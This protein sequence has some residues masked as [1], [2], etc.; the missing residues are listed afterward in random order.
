ML[1]RTVHHLALVA[2]LAL[3][4]T[5]IG[6]TLDDALAL[7]PEDAAGVMAVP[8]LMRLNADMTEMVERS[9]RSEA[10]IAGRPVDMLAAQLG[11]TAAFDDRG[12]FTAWW[13]GQVDTMV[14]AI[15]VA[16]AERFLSA[17]FTREEDVADD[18]WR[19][20]DQ[21]V[22]VRG[23]DKHVIVST[24]ADAVRNYD[25]AGGIAK[26]IR[27][28]LGDDTYEILAKADLSIWAGPDAIAEM[29]T[30]GLAGAEVAMDSD[31]AEGFDRDMVQQMINRMNTLGD[32]LQQLAL[33]VNMDALG[34]GLKG[35]AI[36]DPESAIG[37]AATGGERVSDQPLLSGLPENPFYIA[38]DIDIQGMGGVQRFV[39]LARL[40]GS[41]TLELPGW[42]LDMG[43]H[44]Q[45]IQFAV[46]PSKLG[47]AMGGVL[48][49]ASLFVQTTKPEMARDMLE[50]WVKAADGVDGMVRRTSTWTPDKPLRKG[51]AADE[52]TIREDMLP[53]NE[54][55]EGARSGD[56][57]MQNMI[58]GLIFGPKGMQGLARTVP[59]GL[60]VTFSRRPDV[61]DRATSAATGGDS[62]ASDSVISAMRGWFITNPDMEM[63][64]DMGEIGKLISQMMK[65]IPGGGGM[66]VQIPEDMPPIG[67]ALGVDKGRVST[68]VVVPS[69]VI[70]A[71]IGT[72]SR[73]G[74][75]PQ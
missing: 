65:V 49:D 50:E 21:S 40:I 30:M 20:D 26:R 10:L 9:G 74:F 55:P 51:G 5:T 27:A 43:P 18:A 62:L 6:Q 67:V 54:R 25:P 61:L 44:L 3:T 38:T 13:T 2:T 64:I 53:K 32:G 46:Y 59:D 7:V 12:I 39:D 33:G 69:E 66:V 73:G 28:G 31:Q 34:L 41:D 70:G 29:R 71:I 48:N 35:T 45:G 36:F 15:P 37:K 22:F 1:R 23:I 47:L 14:F 56:W 57:A 11:F 16:D 58:N 52:F 75:G 19:W 60:V 68:A 4:T 42:V 24:D 17:N 63:F 72:A 8:S